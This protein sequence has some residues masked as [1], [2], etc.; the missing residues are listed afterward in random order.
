MNSFRNA[1]YQ[2]TIYRVQVHRLP[3]IWIGTTLIWKEHHAGQ[4]TVQ[5]LTLM[6]CSDVH[7]ALLSK[8]RKESS[9]H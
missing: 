8:T 4:S 7:K 9:S 1:V 3:P 6:V 2:E 5:I